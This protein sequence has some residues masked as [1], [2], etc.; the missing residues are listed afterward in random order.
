MSQMQGF[1]GLGSTA[2]A[3]PAVA[4]GQYFVVHID[5]TTYNFGGWSRATGLSVTWQQLEHREGNLGNYVLYLPGTTKYEPITLSRAAGAQS[6]V[7]QHWLAQTSKN[8]QPLSG[9]IQL[10]PP[11]GPP[12]IIEWRLTEFFPIAWSIESF[13]PAGSKPAI[14]TLKIAHT[15]FL[16]DDMSMVSSM[17]PG[18]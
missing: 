16:S 13:D 15:G 9:T 6:A 1:G 14:E 8:P 3:G 7:V 18:I 4:M 5:N 12:P 10:L 2:Q 11:A 17:A